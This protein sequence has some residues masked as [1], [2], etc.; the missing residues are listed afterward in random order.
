[1]KFSP[2]LPS[3]VFQ[4]REIMEMDRRQNMGKDQGEE[5]GKTENERR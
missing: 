2:D 3:N 5:R 1:M 4:T